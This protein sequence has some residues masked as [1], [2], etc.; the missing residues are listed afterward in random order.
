MNLRQEML[1]YIDSQFYF[2]DNSLFHYT[3][4]KN[5][6]EIIRCKYLR[7]NSHHFLNQKN[8]DN[9][10]IECAYSLIIK[11]LGEQDKLKYL[12]PQFEKYVAK[13]VVFYTASFSKV[14]SLSLFNRYGSYCIEFDKSSLFSNFKEG[15]PDTLIS[16]VEYNAKKQAEI[17]SE[18]FKLYG[19]CANKGEEQLNSLLHALTIILPLFKFS[20]SENEHEC[21]VIQ[22]EGFDQDGKLFQKI[23]SK[24]VLFNLE[25]HIKDVYRI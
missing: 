7:L 19:N 9:C 5:Y 3:H 1:S 6:C 21:R 10:E 2:P 8:K 12:I 17:I 23:A 14:K 15:N 25:L 24:M 11:K 22:L 16:M 20:K 4:E 18:L 13:G